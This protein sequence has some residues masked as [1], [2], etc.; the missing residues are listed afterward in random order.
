MVPNS[1]EE[2]G[3]LLLKNA[4]ILLQKPAWHVLKNGYLGIQND[5]ILYIGAEKPPKKYKA[6]RDLSGHLL[7]PGLYNTHTHAGMSIL[8]GL[9]SGKPLQDWLFNYMMPIENRFTGED[10]SVGSRISMMEM[11]ASGVVSMSDMY[12]E[13]RTYIQDVIQSGMRASLIAPIHMTVTE[14]GEALDKN[15]EEAE[16]LFHEFNGAA[17]GRIH[18]DFSIHAEYTNHAEPIRFYAQLCKKIGARM[19]IHLSETKKEQTECL[20]RRGKT[21]AAFFRDQGVFDNP[22][23]AAHCVWVSDEDLD[24]LKQYDVTAAHNPSSNMKLGSGF[25]P[26]RKMLD[27]HIRITLGTDGDASNNN[28][29]LFEEMHMA[30]MIHSGRQLDP[31]VVQAEDILNMAIPNGAAAQGRPECGELAVGKKADIAAIN[32]DK[33]HLMPVHDVTSLLVYSAQGSDVDLTMVDGK[34]LYDCGEFLTI[35]EDQVKFDLKKSM[36]RLFGEMK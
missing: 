23:T 2:Q 1:N 9:G 6:E 20:A 22:T 30:G 35:D 13:V 12:Q 24:I 18:I 11:L 29:N 34:I 32:L 36:E 27:K 16:G 19:Q 10:I 17:D 33:P 8:R 25:M 4:D 28:Q 5:R 26:I 31:T 14:P 7:M 21:P 3:T 15:L